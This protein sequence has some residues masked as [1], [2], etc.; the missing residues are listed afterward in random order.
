MKNQDT[1]LDTFNLLWINNNN[2]EK[3][4]S[5]IKNHTGDIDMKIKE[6]K[7]YFEYLMKF[8]SV[9]ETEIKWILDIQKEKKE[10]MLEKIYSIKTVYFSDQMS[11]A[12]INNYMN[13]FNYNICIINESLNESFNF[14]AISDLKLEEL[15]KLYKILVNTAKN[16]YHIIINED[17]INDDKFYENHE[18]GYLIDSSRTTH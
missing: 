11:I 14:S 4:L 10:K 12:I 8:K 16:K 5:D 2:W 9:S 13:G 7:T 3:A 17:W 15:E 6:I 1:L 18:Y